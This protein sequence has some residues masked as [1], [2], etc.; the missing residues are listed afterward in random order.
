[1]LPSFFPLTKAEPPVVFLIEKENKP[2]HPTMVEN[3]F[4]VIQ[5]TFS[6]VELHPKRCYKICNCSVILGEHQSFRNYKGF[7]II[8]PKTLAAI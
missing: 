8:S 1:M 4:Q 3:T 2:G 5:T 6:C 7:S